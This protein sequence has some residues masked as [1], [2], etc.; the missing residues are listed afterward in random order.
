MPIPIERIPSHEGTDLAY[1]NQLAEDV[2]YIF[3]ID[4]G[5]LPGM[6]T[7]YWGPEI[8]V[9]VPQ[10][11]LNIDMDALHERRVAELQRSTPTKATLP[12]VFIQNAADEGA[13][14]DPDPGHQPAAAA[15]GLVPP[16]PTQHRRS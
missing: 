8:K 11:A 16:I 5:P 10:P 12:V 9:G 6:N 4:P 13:D 15:A 3:Y 2:G 1:I 7:A 14:P